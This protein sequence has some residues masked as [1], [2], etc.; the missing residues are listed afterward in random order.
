MGDLLQLRASALPL[1]FRCAAAVRPAELRI[2]EANPAADVG[3]V[4]H[5]ALR[6]LSD[7]GSIDWDALPELADRH[8][9][10]P[11]ELGVLCALG[12]RLWRQVRESFQG[13]ITEVELAA[14]PLPGLLLTGHADLLA[15]AANAIRVGD[16]K[17]GRKDSDYSEQL[18][19]YAALAL[20][21]SPDTEQATGTI[22]WVRDGEI[23]NYT[24][25][26]AGLR[27][28]LEELRVRVVEWDGVYRPG[29]QCLYCPR[30][31]ECPA[32]N[33][34]ARRDV[35]AMTDRELVYRAEN[36]I[37]LMSPAEIVELHRKAATV[38][39]YCERIHEA[40]KAHVE[41]VGD[42]E[43]NGLRLTVETQEKRA[44]NVMQAWPV[45]EKNG[46]GD[47]EMARVIDLR[48]G[49]IEE[50]VR[51]RTPKGEKAHAVRK[52]IDELKRAGAIETS[53]NQILKEKRT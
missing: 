1:A 21:Y 19:G 13:A 25:T 47:E 37:A 4:A 20:L 46:F 51:E 39:R 53:E 15:V 50:L 24:M 8:R 41:R 34:L 45:L 40:I 12:T 3:T 36:E 17:T 7:R 33:A 2:D 6:G 27:D 49:R 29:R 30:S 48:L 31:H 42:V 43:A 44:L 10:P 23:E 18:R 52:L 14:R 9:V 11:E 35:A 26:R 38:N 28:W 22:L 32:A 16:W 5:V